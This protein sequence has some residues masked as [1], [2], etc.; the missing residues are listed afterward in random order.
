MRSFHPLRGL[1][2]KPSIFILLISTLILISLAWS[3]PGCSKIF[4]KKSTPTP[5]TEVVLPSTTPTQP[6]Q[7]LPPAL[8]EMNPLPGAQITLKN[9]ITFYFNQPMQHASVEGAVTGEP[10]LSGS[11]AWQDD[12][13]LTFTPDKPLMPGT[14]LTINIG[15]TAQSTQGMAL[16]R[17]ISLAYTTS[18]YLNMVQSLPKADASDVN[19]TSAVVAAFSQPVVPLGAD[20]ASLPAGFTLKPSAVGRGDWIN[21]STYIFYP[22]PALAGGASYQVSINPDL[23]STTGAPLES[24]SSWS[25]STVLPRLVSAHPT[26]NTYNVHL[27]TNVQLNF[28]YSMDA[29]SVEA[30]F[31]LQTSDGNKVSG[32]SGWNAD[33]TTFTFTPT[34]LLQ[35]DVS[36]SVLLSDQTAALGGT[37]LG[38]Q[39]RQTWHTV[40]DLAITGSNPYEGGVRNNFGGLNLYLTSPVATDHIED[41]ITFN[42]IVP[43]MG[44][45]MDE[46]QMSLS[47]YGNFDPN[48]NYTLTVSPDLTDLWGGRLGQT[49]TLHFRTASL[50]PSVQFPY[51][52]DSTF[53]TT[54]DKGILAQ[55]TNVSALPVSVGTLTINDL[56]QMYGNNGYQYRQSFTPL[57]AESWTF[58]PVVPPNRSTTVTIPVSAHG[59]PRSPGLY[60]MKL[61]LPDKSG[62]TNSIIL[63]VSHYQATLKLSPT[64]AFVWAVDLNTNSPAAN[65]P[66]TVYDQSGNPLASGT[67]D[68]NGVFHG[69]ITAYQDP[70]NSSFAMLGQP[71]QDNFGIAM[72]FWNDGV[73]SWDFNIQANY[74]PSKT[75]AYIYT[76]RP[77]YRPGDTVYFRLVVR[78]IS[79]G[80]YTLPDFS[81]YALVLNDSLGKQIASFD[82]PLSGFATAHGEYKLPPDAQPGDYGLTNNDYSLY[83]S[84]KVADYRKPEINLQVAF[85]STDVLSGTALVANVNARYFFDAPAGNLPV[86]WALYRQQAY[87]NLTNYQVGSVDTSWLNVFNYPYNMGMLGNSM[88]QGD[89]RTDANGL[90]T[91]TIPAPAAPGRQ[92]YTLEVTLTD[93]S[94]LPVSARS[95]IYVNPAEYYIGVHPDAWSYQA[96]S[97]AGYEVLVADWNGNPAGARAL[98]AQFQRVVWVRHDPTPDTLGTQFPSYVAEYTPIDSTNLTTSADGTAHL[99]FTPPEP[100]TYQLD[101]SGDSTLTQVIVWVG[102]TG[103]AVWPSLPN[104]RL[105]LVADRDAY[106]PGDTAQVFIPNPFGSAALGLLTVERGTVMRYQI[107]HLE[108]GGSTIPLALSTD[109]APNVYIAVTL[110]GQDDQGYPDF[111]QGY[112]NLTIDPS[113]EYLKVSLISHPVRTGPG[114]P[115]TFDLR[116]TDANGAPVQGEFSLSVVDKAVLALAEPTAANI[117]SAFYGQQ[118]L[119]VRTG[120]S[121]AA[122]GQRMRYMPGGMGGGGGGEAPESVTRENFPDTAYWDA[123][124]VTDANGEATVNMS[125]PDSLTTWQVLVRGLTKDTLVGETQLEVITTQDLLIRPVT[126][127]FLVVGDHALLSA[128]VQ[129]NTQNAL[130]GTATLQ[131]TG[132]VLDEPNKL[133]QPVSVPPYGRTRLEWWG[134]A[135]DAASA[136]LRFSVQAGDLQDAVL[137]AKGVLPI[138]RYTAPQTFATSGTLPEGG[139]RLEL[140]SLPVTFDAKSGALSVEL[141][142]SLA[143]TMIDALNAL[144]E[145][146]PYDS[147]DEVL[148][149]F[150]PNLV[151]YSTLQTFG[152]ESPDLKARLDR[153]LN[154]GLEHLLTLQNADGGWGWWQSEESDAYITAYVLFGLATTRD[155]G[156]TVPE[157]AISKAV[158]YISTTMITPT[159][160]TQT[161]MLDRLAFENFALKK[162]GAGNLSSANQLYGVRDQLSPWAKGLL[163]LSLDLASSSSTQ[164]PTLISDLQAT[165]IRSATGVHWEGANRDWRNM[166]STLSNTAIVVYTLAQLEPASTLLPD[167]VNYLMSNRQ[168]TGSWSSSYESSW[169]LLSMDEVMKGTGELGS[170]YTFSSSLNGTQIASGQ[171]GGETQL[172]PVVTSLPISNLYPH[173]PNAL[174]IQRDPGTG[175]LYYTAALNVYRPVED[176]A[177]LDRGISVSRSYFMQGADLKT[178]TPVSSAKVGDTLTTRLTI[179]LPNDAYHFIVEDYIPAGTEILNTNLKTSQLGASGEPGPLYDPRDPYSQ[180]WGWWLF[181]PAQIYDD[182]ISWTASYL[183]AGTYELTYTL[184]IL[185]PGEYKLLPARAWMFYF[186]EVQGNSA[187][188]MLEIKP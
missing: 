36:F 14:S 117:T 96:G 48:T 56:V 37:P 108:P 182:H 134:T 157:D 109:D 162:A 119:N 144:V 43:N 25:F 46:G 150:L 185:Q 45:W 64:E 58:H 142:P 159:Q 149:R 73:T 93:E 128:V 104:Q 26:D 116:I 8:V 121:L 122:S 35:R 173:D 101:L 113:F 175:R 39:I 86:H 92:Q 152:I 188:G 171:A 107:L 2:R 19:P 110:L 187:G 29:A 120:I 54:R 61:D 106:K 22:H 140:V 77:I 55:V 21:T 5:T 178:A 15:T 124:I 129:N 84:F 40:S 30:N 151:T 153:T 112:V 50:D 12:S 98:S 133:T 68:V 81:S 163:T 13:T 82:L 147:T 136:S 176:I 132:F 52:P 146:Y 85:Q 75:Y 51:N 72:T 94:G 6:P 28:S 160:T 53:L 131:A 41:Y 17:P 127:R 34:V 118:N 111:R 99:S 88:A 91:L 161:W 137:V 102:G 3:L 10:A 183:P 20:P 89:V 95:S 135:E 65:L 27:D 24:T 49:Y 78:Q 23:T 184:T 126:P 172:N 168:A 63:A 80:R 130:E 33:F 155:A 139:Q 11:F 100:G 42:P 164:V 70:Y 158:S 76:D 87:F 177:P 47:I 170:N 74:F 4:P 9:P 156:I 165:A 143:A 67:T 7:A 44:A 31:S 115:V 169:I 62:Y 66:V 32:Q 16:L 103:Q 174:V 166:T 167:A 97:K 60:F 79:N 141:D 105:R 83:G 148:S 38:E 90:A 114:E 1:R 179:V 69:T 180:G 18:P 154:Q 123:Q 57:D 186:P 59:L 138:L 71:G 145:N 125:L 181:N